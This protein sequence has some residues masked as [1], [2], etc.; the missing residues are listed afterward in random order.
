MSY[1]NFFSG[2]FM[3]VVYYRSIWVN[4]LFAKKKV[5]VNNI[6]AVLFSTAV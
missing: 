3:R 1:H 2:L 6:S 4:G 5:L